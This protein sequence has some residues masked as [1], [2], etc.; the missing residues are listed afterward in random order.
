MNQHTQAEI[1]VLAERRRQI[2]AEDWTPSHDDEYTK[3][4]LVAAAAAYALEAVS[5]GNVRGVWFHRLWPWHQDY[6]KPKSR[7]RDL[8]RAA[9][10]MLAEI[11]RIDRAEAEGAAT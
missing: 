10:L 11:E 1:D 3:G 4:E 6:W 7:R 5:E 2:E 9:A 8:V